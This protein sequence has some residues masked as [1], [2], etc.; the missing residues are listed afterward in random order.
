MFALVFDRFQP[1]PNSEV[2]GSRPNPRVQ[3]SYLNISGPMHYRKMVS[4]EFLFVSLCYRKKTG[5]WRHQSRQKGV[6]AT[7]PKI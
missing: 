6:A 1:V 2:P 5:W 3:N 4:L 7:G